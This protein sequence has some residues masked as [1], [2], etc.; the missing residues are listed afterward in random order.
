[1]PRIQ[2]NEI[3]TKIMKINLC[4]VAEIDGAAI[5]MNSKT[6]GLRIII[7]TIISWFINYSHHG[8]FFRFFTY[9][10]TL[11]ARAVARVATQS[12][13]IDWN[14]FFK[15]SVGIRY[16]YVSHRLRLESNMPRSWH[17]LIYFRIQCVHVQFNIHV[18]C[19]VYS[20][21]GMPSTSSCLAVQSVQIEYHNNSLTMSAVHWKNKRKFSCSMHRN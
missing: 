10:D 7:F 16:Y 15:Y 8:N 2:M 14:L 5:S 11:F 3:Q 9:N 6:G 12:K 4:C 19:T 13:I 20:V 17:G 21:H 18:H 1:M